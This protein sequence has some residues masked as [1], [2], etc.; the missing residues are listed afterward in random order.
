MQLK[1][2][3]DK[4][5]A[6]YNLD[7]GTGKIR[8]IYLQNNDMVRSLFSGWLAPFADLGASTVTI[9]DTGGTDHLPF[10]AVG[11][12]GFQFIQD[13][14]EYDS[15]THHSNMDTYDRAQASRSDAGLGDHCIFCLPYGQPRQEMLPSESR[16]PKPG[17]DCDAFQERHLY[18]NDP[19]I[20]SRRSTA[21]QLHCAG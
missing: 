14:V 1:P 11:L 4:V 13:R 3:H 7:N 17:N 15:R 10:D 21:M 5:S 12:P 18:D 20:L 2:G 19:P 9:R 6:Y 8:G 16:C